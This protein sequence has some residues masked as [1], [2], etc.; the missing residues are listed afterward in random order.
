[1][2]NHTLLIQRFAKALVSYEDEAVVQKKMVETLSE[3]LGHH[4]HTFAPRV[5]ELGC[6]TGMLSRTLMK[7]FAPAELIVND[8]CPDVAVCYKNML[9]TTFMA[10]DAEV[11]QWPTGVDLVASTSAIQWF[12]DPLCAFQK[13]YDALNPGGVVAFATFGPRNLYELNHLTGQGLP[14]LPLAA[15]Q[16]ALTH[17]FTPLMIEESE[18]TLTFESVR[19]LLSHLKQTGVT[20]THT[21]QVWTRSKLLDLDAKYRQAFVRA[22]ERLPLTYHSIYCIGV[23]S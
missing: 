10:G 5:F 23:K 6:G 1:M 19:T 15:Y 9:R 2:I 8:I 22:D 20:A 11:A 3:A 13:A 12:K 16:E 4:F 7:R 18:E 17:Y 21:P 14:Y